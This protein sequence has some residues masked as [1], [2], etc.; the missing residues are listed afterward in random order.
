MHQTTRILVMILVSRLRASLG[1]RTNPYVTVTATAAETTQAFHYCSSPCHR[2]KL[3]MWND[4]VQRRFQKKDKLICIGT[5]SMLKT[6]S[7]YRG[8]RTLS[9]A[10]LVDEDTPQQPRSSSNA[11]VVT[12]YTLDGRR[13]SESEQELYLSTD[14]MRLRDSIVHKHCRT[15]HLYDQN[16]PIAAHTQRAFQR[17]TEK[18]S[19]SLLLTEQS[20]Q[21]KIILDSGCGTGRSTLLLGELFPKHLV[22]GVDR[23]WSRL[24]KIPSHVGN[25]SK[26]DTTKIHPTDDNQENNLLDNHRALQP[27]NDKY[28]N[29][30]IAVL[31]DDNHVELVQQVRE[32][33]WLVR[34][35]L[36]DFWRLLRKHH[37]PIDR[38][39]LL[40]PNPYPKRR[41]GLQHRWY[42]HPIFPWL[43]EVSDTTILRSNWKLYLSEYADA[44]RYY[45][46]YY[47][48]SSSSSFFNTAFVS[49]SGPSSY[50]N[51]HLTHKPSHA[52]TNFEEKYWRVGE[53][54][55]ELTV[56]RIDTNHTS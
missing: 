27:G 45:A 44:V 41:Q 35:E 36:A 37:I 23:S 8:Q 12:R 21:K 25:R 7:Q 16:R 43:C 39:Y 51:I 17:L 6:L 47:Q 33:V 50:P 26:R 42:A 31:D 46:E 49:L 3:H 1:I 40:Y 13:K 56:T 2:R 10:S 28:K 52:W 48:E 4:S 14:P 24:A 30:S 18:S 53:S 19:S 32:N 55:Y 22:I 9:F 34:A 38:H 11:T 5:M 15:R 29:G 20:P 54:T